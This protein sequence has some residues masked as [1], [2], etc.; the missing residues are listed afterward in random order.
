[1]AKINLVRSLRKFG[2]DVS[3]YPDESEGLPRTQLLAH[4]GVELVLDIGAARGSYVADLREFGYTGEAFSFEPLPASFE[5]LKKR[6]LNDPNWHA[7]NGAVGDSEG[8]ITIN[9]S[10]NMDSSS[11]LP[12]LDAHEA[13][14]PKSRVVDSISVSQLTVDSFLADHTSDRC[15]LKLDVQGYE[16]AVLRGAKE[17][18]GRVIGF[19]LELSMIPLYEGQT[20]F[21]E[22]MSQMAE[23]GFELHRLVPGFSDPDSGRM[24]QADG[25]FFRANS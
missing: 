9:V 5:I 2:L 21:P 15:F 10:E 20:L 6:S 18:M 19:E 11:A 7:I 24:L 17:S 25:M 23:L 13:A 14:A 1:M 8:E 4:H 3:R 22:M 12:M 16:P